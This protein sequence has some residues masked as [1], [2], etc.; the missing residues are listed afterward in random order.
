MLDIQFVTQFV[1]ENFEKVSPSKGG[2]HFHTRCPLCGDSKKSLSKK[3]F[4][5]DW[6]NGK[7]RYHC[8]NCDRSGGIVKLYCLIKGVGEDKAID[9][10][11]LVKKYNPE[12]F[13]RFLSKK[14]KIHT[15]E[16]AKNFTN[17]NWILD[18]CAA[19]D[20][21][22]DS[23]FYDKWVSILKTFRDDRK[24]PADYK[25]Y[26]AYKG[27]YKDRIIV[28]IYK[29]NDIIYFQGRRLPGSS[30]EPKYR[31]PSTQKEIAI[32]NR[33]KFNKDRSIIVTEGLVDAFMI[34]DQG[35]T[36][37]GKEMS[38]DFIKILF[39]LTKRDIILAY[40]ND[41]EGIRSLRKFMYG[42]K[43]CREVRYFLMPEQYKA[44]K[45]INILQVK[46]DIGNMY[47]FAVS[48]SYDYYKTTFVLGGYVKNAN[49]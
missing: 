33:E 18:D 31:N 22:V 39:G 36:C 9:D 16:K 21:K 41:R 23:M 42:N 34:G 30:M 10:L 29:G 37:L 25:L 14:A 3:R 17:H 2:T 8:F 7:M 32:L 44:A 47:V 12:R 38:E 46:Y 19:D 45:D 1:Y 13:K 24:I 43:Y 6:N 48:N 35:T 15:T 40:D 27:V 49:N 5:L 11:G 4:H 26:Y 20:L 28:P